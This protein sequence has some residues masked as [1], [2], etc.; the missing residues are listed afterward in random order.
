[1]SVFARFLRK[2]KGAEEASTAKAADVTPAADAP[3]EEGSASS[4]ASD[5][6]EARTEDAPRSDVQEESAKA[7]QTPDAAG[8]CTSRTGAVAE[9]V[10]IPK[11]QS[12]EQ[13]AD[14]E[15]GEGVRK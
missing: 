7:A 1:M 14:N 9:P 3:A 10:E 12:A 2:P 13:A 15:A 8:C 4:A 11:Q 6:P 5:T